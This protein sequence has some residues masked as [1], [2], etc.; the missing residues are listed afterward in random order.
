MVIM[1]NIEDL[2][3]NALDNNIPIMQD[4]GIEFLLNF[5]KENNIKRILEIGTAVGY[6]A[7]KM[8]SL[9]DNITITSI[10]RDEERYNE[11][12][13]N[14]SDFKLNDRITLIY[15]DAFNVELDNKFDLIFI[16][17]AKG[18]NIEFFEK[19]K[20][21]LSDSGYIITDNLK[22]HGYVDMELSSIES[23]NI[24]GLVRKIR[25]YLDF[26]KNNKEFETTFFDLGD[27]VSVSK[28]KV[29]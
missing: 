4:E 16:D 21:N 23:R 26:L 19:F 24:R 2:R 14:V 20:V 29:Q 1:F 9:D 5:I 28:R 6:S 3:L 17:A 27:G 10:E 7:I 25:N 15:D 18:K 8:A 22:F 13:K 11:A 12:V